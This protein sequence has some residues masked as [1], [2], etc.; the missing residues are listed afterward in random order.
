M[1][2]VG[3]NHSII[4]GLNGRLQNWCSQTSKRLHQF[5]YE[6]CSPLFWKKRLYGK[7]SIKAQIRVFKVFCSQTLRLCLHSLHFFMAEWTPRACPDTIGVHFSCLTRTHCYLSTHLI[8]LFLPFIYTQDLCGGIKLL[9][10]EFQPLY[11][12]GPFTA[13]K[14]SKYKHAPIREL[15]S[16]QPP[17]QRDVCYL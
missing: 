1:K 15:A 6:L 8:W 5:L 10:E 3:H 12:G 13:D 9:R 17:P 2:T 4:T 11:G 16:N 14:N 7:L